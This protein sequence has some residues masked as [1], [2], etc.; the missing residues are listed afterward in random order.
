MDAERAITIIISQLLLQSLAPDKFS[1]LDVPKI[2][3]AVIDVKVPWEHEKWQQIYGEWF[4]SSGYEQVEGPR[5]QVG[6]EIKVG[7]EKQIITEEIEIEY[8][9]PVKKVR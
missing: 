8:W 9:I 4:P 6:P 2:T 7:E 5:I 1:R 3:L